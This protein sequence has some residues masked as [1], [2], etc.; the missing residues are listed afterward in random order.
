L[1]AKKRDPSLFFAF[2]WAWLFFTT[3]ALWRQGKRSGLTPQRGVVHLFMPCQSL[4][5][6]HRFLFSFLLV[7]F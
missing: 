3:Q 2:G 4:L 1:V 6:P 7:S 5:L